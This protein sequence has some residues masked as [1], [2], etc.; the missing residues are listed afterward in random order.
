MLSPYARKEWLTILAVGATVAAALLLLSPGYLWWLAIIVLLVAVGLA[1]FFR[2]PG[3]SVPP[4]RGVIVAPADGRV[5]SIHD[6]EHYEPFGEGA[7]CIRIFLSVLD[8]HIN[9]A[10]CHGMVA[11]ITHKGGEFLNAL[12][13]RSAEVNESNL[14]VLVH[15]V[16]RRP[17]AA[18]RQVAGMLARTIHCSLTEGQVVQRGS[19][20]G[21][22][23][24]GS[25]TEVY[26]PRSVE[27]RVQVV[28]GEKVKAGS[29]IVAV[30]A[31][32]E[33]NDAPTFRRDDPAATTPGGAQAFSV[34]TDQ[35]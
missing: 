25:T 6:L 33:A 7:V 21:I 17:V 24:L 15:P 12:N 20:I 35:A 8:V 30:V 13:P 22:I 14:I 3:R 18:V 10:P 9:R 1:L 27:P 31:T 11:S 26:L 23:K 34:P 2:D 5:S 4:A 29:S 32:P 28:E 16:Q 19:R